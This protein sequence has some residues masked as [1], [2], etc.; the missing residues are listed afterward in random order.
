MTHGK[1]LTSHLH[2]IL[3][4]GTTFIICLAGMIFSN[5]PTAEGKTPDNVA[6]KTNLLYDAST[7]PNLGL[8]VGLG[9]KNTI[10]LFYG[11]NPW[12]F[13]KDDG[14]YAKHWMLM[15][16]F[17]WWTCTKFN[18]HFLGVHLLGG[19]Y[20]AANLSLPVPGF[21]FGGDN[22]RTDVKDSR[23]QGWMAG[24]GVTYGY[25]W[26]LNKH[27]NIEAEIG[28]GYIYSRYDIYAC[29]KCGARLSSGHTNYM[30]ITKL[31]VSFLYI[32]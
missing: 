23:C 20:N 19:E 17:R 2:G 30:G 4:K 7:T 28:V 12:K 26:I 14:K 6:L 18:G 5:I 10:Q 27:W 32:F 13:G 8:E 16:E 22:L 3:L 15:P 21:F 31:G 25:Q 29:H 9:R 24:G 11:I 1:N